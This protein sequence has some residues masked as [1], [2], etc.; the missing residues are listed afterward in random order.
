MTYIATFKRLRD[1]DKPEFVRVKLGK[2]A[3]IAQACDYA[4]RIQ[5]FRLDV[6]VGEYNLYDVRPA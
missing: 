5:K 6:P 4:R 3:G 1:S 2:Q